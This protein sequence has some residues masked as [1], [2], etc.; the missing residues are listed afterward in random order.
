MV[1][2]VVSDVDYAMVVEANTGNL[3]RALDSA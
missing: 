3:A 2:R 1:K